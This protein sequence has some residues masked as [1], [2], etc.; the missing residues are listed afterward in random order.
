MNIIIQLKKNTS[1]LSA[2]KLSR[3][4]VVRDGGA[5]A[6]ERPDG[7]LPEAGAT[8][9]QRVR[10]GAAQVRAHAA[11]DHGRGECSVIIRA[12]NKHSRSLKFYNVQSQRRPLLWPSPG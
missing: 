9:G 7:L 11:A 2:S 10:G 12:G 3:R 5:E 8:R 6:A 1:K 4:G